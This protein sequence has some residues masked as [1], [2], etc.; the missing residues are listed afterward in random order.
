MQWPRKI[1]NAIAKMLEEM[2]HGL[3]IILKFPVKKSVNDSWYDDA[4]RIYQQDD[5]NKFV[6]MNSMTSPFID[7]YVTFVDLSML[8]IQ[9]QG[10]RLDTHSKLVLLFYEC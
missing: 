10:I 5:V 9:M 2:E 4:I 7:C 3:D 1:G 8:S 6:T